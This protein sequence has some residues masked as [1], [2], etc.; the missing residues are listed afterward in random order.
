M[1]RKNEPPTLIDALYRASFRPEKNNH[2]R[3]NVEMRHALENARRFII[4]E[5][6]AAFM[7]ELANESFLRA[8]VSFD[9]TE[10]PQNALAPR[11]VDSLRR[12][13]RLPHDSVWIE[14]PLR[15]YQRRSNEIRASVPAA[16]SEVPYREGWLIQSHPKIDNAYIMHL[17]T[18]SDSMNEDTDGIHLWTFPFAFGW[19]SDDNPLPW[20][21]TVETRRMDGTPGFP[22]T[23]LVGIGGYERDNINCVRSPLIEDI[24]AGLEGPYHD[25]LMEWT[26]TLRRVWALLATIDHLPIVKGDVRQSKGFLARGRIRKYL[27]HQTITLNVPAKRDTRVLAR[28]MVA[29]AHRKRHEVRAHWRDDWRNPPSRKCNPHLWEFVSE[30]DPDV[31]RCELCHGRQIHIHKHERG[32]ASLGYVTHDYRVTHDVE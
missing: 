7:A 6:M 16:E 21:T 19:V 8:G 23:F 31:I 9:N 1:K 11:I 26:G 30:D 17:F 18:Q 24:R 12:S 28:Q 10:R 32:D 25:L 4:D 5:P 29:I 13:A 14:Y 27:S 2:W 15:A 3:S 20:R 22:S